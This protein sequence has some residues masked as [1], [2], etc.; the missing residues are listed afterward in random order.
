MV[1]KVSTTDLCEHKQGWSNYPTSTITDDVSTSMKQ[2][3]VSSN[4]AMIHERGR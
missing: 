2:K 3:L 4:Q 1:K